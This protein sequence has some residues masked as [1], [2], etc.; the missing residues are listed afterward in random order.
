MMSIFSARNYDLFYV[1]PQHSL[2]QTLSGPPK[3]FEIANVRH[4]EIFENFIF[5]ELPE[6]FRSSAAL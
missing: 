6:P 1:I 2:S 5:F 4:R 3:K